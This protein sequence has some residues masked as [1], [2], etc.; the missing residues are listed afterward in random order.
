MPLVDTT[1]VDAALSRRA[2]GI[3]SAAA[4]ALFATACVVDENG[5]GFMTALAPQVDNATR[6]EFLALL[7]AAGLLAAGCASDRGVE[8]EGETRTLEDFFGATAIPA[9]PQRIVAGDDTTMA[10]M[11]ALGVTPIAAAY[12]YNSLPKHLA[13]QTTG[14]SD[15]T[16][17]DGFDLEKALALD[18]DLIIMVAGLVGDPFNEEAY[19]QAKAAVPS[20]AY[21]YGYVYIEDITTN[22]A[23]VGRALQKESAADTLIA[24]F[25]QR[26]AELRARVEAAGLAN[27]P[28]STVR[29]SAEGNYS[30]RIGSS[31]SIAFR[32][33]GMSQ[34]EGQRDPEEFRIDL[35]LENLTI[36]NSADSLFVYVDDNAPEERDRVLTSP[37]WATLRPVQEGKIHFVDSGIWNSLDLTGLNLI[38]DDI[39]KFFIAPNER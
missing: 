8:P 6:R 35:S 12:N 27:K 26:A 28:V 22:L 24:Q 33:L 11:L 32:A 5:D 18:P 3:G 13:S 16:S 37:L 15:I 17:E 38:L 30:I 21:Q 19:W 36:L 1:T 39:E 20:F 4:I 7:G 34:P 31:E 25:R 10:S 23:E 9:N 14:V 2:F 29:L